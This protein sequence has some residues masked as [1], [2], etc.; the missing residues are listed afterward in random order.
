MI[1][2]LALF[3]CC[4]FVVVACNNNTITKV[5]IPIGF[6]KINDSC[7]VHFKNKT[8]EKSIS[9]TETIVVQ[10][11][12]C[13]EFEIEIPFTE[14]VIP[15]ESIAINKISK[16]NLLWTV[17]DRLHVGDTIVFCIPWHSSFFVL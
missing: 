2:R 7:F 4:S 15:E 9:N 16:T 14:K 1:L 10:K 17:K 11:L 12:I 6:D 8:E 5:T 13:N 3:I